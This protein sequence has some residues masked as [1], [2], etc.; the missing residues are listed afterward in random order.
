[1]RF[2]LTTDLAVQRSLKK[3]QQFWAAGQTIQGI[4]HITPKAAVYIWGAYYTN[5]NFRNVLTATAKSPTT[6]PQQINYIS[7][8][9][10]RFKHI[11]IGFKKYLVGAS[12]NQKGWNLYAS[13][14]LGLLPGKVTNTHTVDI[15]TA[16]YNVP[17]LNGVANFKRLTAD[18]ALGY[19]KPLATD[20]YIYAEGKVWVPASDYPSKHI[21]IN[22]N[23]PFAIMLGIGLRILF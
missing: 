19:E 2:S 23:A 9:K 10:M 11:S 6:L 3:E 16:I 1:M 8:S 17:V 5:G 21:F 14:G 4:F 7:R 22:E 18:L 13:A 12:D 20:F 15:D